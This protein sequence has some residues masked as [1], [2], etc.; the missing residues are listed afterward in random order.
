MTNAN[1]TSQVSAIQ[2]ATAV[3]YRH[4][5]FNRSLRFTSA[6]DNSGRLRFACFSQRED[7]ESVDA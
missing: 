2:P 4:L 5:Y 7:V 3:A 6:V 1:V